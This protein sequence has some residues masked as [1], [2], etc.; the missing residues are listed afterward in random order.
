M[1]DNNGASMARAKHTYDIHTKKG[2]DALD[3]A[4]AARLHP[5]QG[6]MR[7]E[8]ADRLGAPVRAVS[9]ALLRLCDAGVAKRS[10][11]M[12]A[13]TYTRLKE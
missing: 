1:V 6:R 8:I 10:G 7:G 13:P 4:V 9:A 11:P 2:R 12:R 5:E 3:K